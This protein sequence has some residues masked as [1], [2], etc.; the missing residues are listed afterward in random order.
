MEDFQ[1]RPVTCPSCFSECC[2][3]MIRK[4]KF[5]LERCLNCD[6][7]GAEDAARTGKP[8][9]YQC[10]AGL[11][12]IAAPLI[13][14]GKHIGAMYCGQVL[15]EP[16]KEKD[17]YKVAVEMGL[18]PN[19]YLAAIKKLP[20]IPEENI[21]AIA[22]SL[23]V[24]A[25]TFSS[26]AHNQIELQVRKHEL[27]RA[28]SCL[29]HVFDT[30]SDIVLI[31][32]N[33]QKII[34]VNKMAEKCI[35]KTAAELMHTPLT[36][37]LR[38]GKT[39][40]HSLVNIYKAHK[41]LEVL[42][43]TSEG[44]IQCLSSS[45]LLRDDRGCTIGAVYLLHP[46]EKTVKP[47]QRTSRSCASLQLQDIIGQSP[48]MQEIKQMIPRLA[49][50]NSNILLEGES[51]TG[52][53][54][55]A[56]AIHNES[57]RRNGPFVA[58]NCGAIPKELIHSELFG[59]TEGAFTGAKKGGSAG[60]FELAS[61]GTLFLDEIGDMPLEQQVV[62]LRVLQEKKVTRVGGNSVIPLDVR[63]I[64]ATNKKL[65]DEI[66]RGNFRSDL[67]YRLSI[68]SIKVPPLRERR[69]DI[70][71]LFHYFLNV[72]GREKR[73]FKP[74]G[75]EVMKCLQEYTWPGNVR[76]LQN[77]VERILHMTEGD[78][79]CVQDLPPNIIDSHRHRH[80]VESEAVKE[81]DAFQLRNN[82]RQLKAEK[83]AQRIK[84]LLNENGGNVAQTARTL[85]ISRNSLYRKIKQYDIF[86]SN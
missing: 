42:M 8:A 82:Q 59:Y 66:A 41:N 13:V 50:S 45:R 10:H 78:V 25:T 40:I 51:G 9:I 19:E 2:S 47:G 61:G 53:E 65:Q 4:S 33:T 72:I 70:P 16:P 34:Q 77:T 60:K 32:D 64:C 62:L 73:S 86:S 58:V 52:K 28:T 54:V 44:S 5:G 11:I 46:V 85:G 38:D 22:D 39:E 14:D 48:K 57:S 79:L 37:V 75:A 20:V 35:G 43:D 31:S 24:A 17:F 1:G 63:V 81:E 30:M 26:V 23:H 29:N 12:D 7:Q 49:R 69:A 84:D 74:I 80:G 56:Q 76:E 21:H 71:L 68:L 6:M 18:D 67:Y 55:I 83:E 27:L 36:E 3:Q 15:C